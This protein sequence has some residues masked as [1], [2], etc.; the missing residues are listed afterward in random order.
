MTC[1]AYKHVWQVIFIPKI[2]LTDFSPHNKKQL[3]SKPFCLWKVSDDGFNS[4]PRC[5]KI[6]LMIDLL[7]SMATLKCRG[8]WDLNGTIAI[9][10]LKLKKLKVHLILT[11]LYKINHD[12]P[13]HAIATLHLGNFLFSQSV[14]FWFQ[15]FSFSRPLP[16]FSGFNIGFQGTFNCGILVSLIEGSGDPRRKWEEMGE[17]ERE[18]ERGRERERYMN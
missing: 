10:C 11:K 16:I 3:M 1:C 18:R 17:R 14:T 2:I 15:N 6:Q 4:L 12:Y 8:L 9:G 5:N 7:H 13:F